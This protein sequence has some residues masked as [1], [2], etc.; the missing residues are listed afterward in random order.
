MPAVNGFAACVR[1]LI[2]AGLMPPGALGWLFGVSLLLFAASLGAMPVVIARMR[3]DYFVRSEAPGAGRR[4]PLVRWALLAAKNLLGLILLPAG[5]AMLVLPGQ[6]I[7]TVL[8]ALTLLNFPGKRRLELRI[9]R[10]RH[11]RRAADWIRARAGRPPFVI[12]DPDA[13]S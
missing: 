8:V 1:G 2:P 13:A 3:A 12:P 4:Y 6:G 7:I 10:Q 9:V 11:V 5:L